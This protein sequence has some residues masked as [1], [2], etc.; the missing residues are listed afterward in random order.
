MHLHHLRLNVHVGFAGKPFRVITLKILK[1]AYMGW[2]FAATV[3]SWKSSEPQCGQ[4]LQSDPLSVRKSMPTCPGKW[5]QSPSD[6]KEPA[7]A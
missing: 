7:Q 3:R 5:P 4:V 2:C 1:E 6:L